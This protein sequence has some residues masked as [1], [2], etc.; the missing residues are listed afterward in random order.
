MREVVTGRITDEQWRA[1]IARRLTPWCGAAAVSVVAA[2]TEPAGS[3]DDEVLRVL[4]S[5]RASGWQVGLLTN[6][7]TRLRSDLNRLR[8]DCEFDLIVN[9]A[10]LGLAKPDPEVFE[11]ACDQF[12]VDPRECVFVDDNPVNVAAASAVGLVAHLY[13]GPHALEELLGLASDTGGTGA[14]RT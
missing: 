11:A 14:E 8:L 10:E 9:S 2:W 7:T 12:S 5:A 4:R 3:V 1:D 6:A 13:A